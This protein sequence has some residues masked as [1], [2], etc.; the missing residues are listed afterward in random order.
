M[1]FE[2]EKIV[3]CFELHS[4]FSRMGFFHKVKNA[5]SFSFFPT[6]FSNLHFFLANIEISLHCIQLTFSS[7]CWC[8][9]SIH[10]RMRWESINDVFYF[11]FTSCQQTSLQKSCVWISIQKVT[12]IFCCLVQCFI[13]IRRTLVGFLSS[14]TDYKCLILHRI[15][16]GKRKKPKVIVTQCNVAKIHLKIFVI[17]IVRI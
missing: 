13:F 10:M 2:L 14:N 16:K 5:S 12:L 9:W 3:Q 4:S 1:N 6:S 8:C 17:F 11:T 7:M 15:W